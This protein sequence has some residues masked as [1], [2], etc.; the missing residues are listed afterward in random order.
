MKI[1]PLAGPLLD[2]RLFEAT[3]GISALVKPESH[4][5]TIIAA[6]HDYIEFTGLKKEDLIGKND[7]PFLSK[8]ANVRSSFEHVIENKSTH[9]IPVQRFDLQDGNN[10][11]V[12]YGKVKN[13]P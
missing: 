11:I 2:F 13:I 1:A 7:L 4:F 6:C 12:K 8:D 10:S 3:P 5:Y 9:E